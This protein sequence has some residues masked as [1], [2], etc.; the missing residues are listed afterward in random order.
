MLVFYYTTLNVIFVVVS[1]HQEAECR[2]QET[3]IAQLRESVDEQVQKVEAMQ[4]ELRKQR[5]AH[6]EQ[7]RETER[8]L[9]H[10]TEHSHTDAIV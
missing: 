6:C 9:W 4:R 3:L 2:S 1:P 10:H 8:R 5:A 7:V